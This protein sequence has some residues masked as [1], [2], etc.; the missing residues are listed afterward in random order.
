MSLPFSYPELADRFAQ[1]RGWAGD[2]TDGNRCAL[3]MGIALKL[4]PGET[5]ANFYGQSSARDHLR[6]QP[7]LA[8]MFVKAEDLAFHITSTYGPPDIRASGTS[9]LKEIRGLKGVL[10]LR[11]CWKT[12]REKLFFSKSKSGDHIDLWDGNVIEIYR[13][14]QGANNLV[15]NAERV[16]LWKTK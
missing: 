8:K 2:I 12:P 7:F 4:K 13:H 11:N 14:E 9:A 6:N 15:T 16:L 10:L 1:I 3:V 5:D